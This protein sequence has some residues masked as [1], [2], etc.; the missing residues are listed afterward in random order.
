MRFILKIILL[1]T[2]LTG[3][4]LLLL[5][6]QFGVPII[7]LILLFVIL[8]VGIFRSRNR[9]DYYHQSD[10]YIK[11]RSYNNSRKMWSKVNWEKGPTEEQKRIAREIGY[12]G[13]GTKRDYWHG[14]GNILR[15][16]RR[17]Y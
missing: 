15:R 3:C 10:N 7:F 9:S 8:G 6:N 5:G 2:F 11:G 14:I 17:R 4:V 13:G 1:G 16:R 12:K